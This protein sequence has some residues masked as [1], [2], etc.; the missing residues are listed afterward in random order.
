MADEDSNTIESILFS[1]LEKTSL[2]EIPQKEISQKTTPRAVKKKTPKTTP[3]NISKLN[4]D[5]V[6]SII[7]NHVSSRTN[8]SP[9]TPVS[10]IDTSDEQKL[11]LGDRLRKI[12]SNFHDKIKKKRIR[13]KIDQIETDAIRLASIGKEEM[14][15][16]Q[17]LSPSLVSALETE[18]LKYDPQPKKGQYILTWLY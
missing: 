9:K 12:H 16:Y 8:K 6:R 15:F 1:G 18:G 10:E 3:R 11:N 4:F 13:M 17:P 5:N 14:I 2:R 7:E